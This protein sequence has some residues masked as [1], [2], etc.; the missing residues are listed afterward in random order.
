M[1]AMLSMTKLDLAVLRAAADGADGAI[2]SAATDL[3]DL[4]DQM[5]DSIA[6][7]QVPDLSQLEPTVTSLQEACT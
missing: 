2:S 4:Y 7:G 5:A 1:K 3:A 6:A